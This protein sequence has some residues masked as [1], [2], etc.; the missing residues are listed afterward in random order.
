[1]NWSQASPLPWSGIA[2]QWNTAAKANSVSVAATVAGS[3]TTRVVKAESISM[4]A[5]VADSAT[6]AHTMPESVSIAQTA[7]VTS[8]GGFVFSDSISLAATADAT[9]SHD[10]TLV[11]SISLAA[12]ANAITNLNYPVSITLASEHSI[13]PG[14]F[15]MNSISFATTQGMSVT[16]SFLWNPV[17]EASTTWTKVEYPN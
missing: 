5:T 12:T 13:F 11:N 6:N 9:L 8:V 14:E 4:A 7:A 15:Y 16:D 2:T 10:A 17:D 1:M 3:S